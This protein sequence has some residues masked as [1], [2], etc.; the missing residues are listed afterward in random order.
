MKTNKYI[1]FKAAFFLIVFALQNIAS[2]AS[3]IGADMVLHT[4]LH[5]SEETTKPLIDADNENHQ[6]QTETAKY[7]YESVEKDCCNDNDIQFHHLDK[8]FVKKTHNSTPYFVI[9]RCGFFGIDIFKQPSV[10]NEKYN[11]DRFLIPP[12]DI[13]VL[14]RSFQI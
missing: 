8:N 7:Y 14:I 4:I 2:A 11:P 6:K 12:P 9:P 10:S 1:H 5:E 13:R 3:T